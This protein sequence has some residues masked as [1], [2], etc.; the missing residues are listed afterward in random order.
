M[1]LVETVNTSVAAPL[2]KLDI[3][4][5][6][7]PGGRFEGS[8][9]IN[10]TI[11][12]AQPLDRISPNTEPE[13]PIKTA[14]LDFEKDL[15]GIARV[16]RFFKEG[17]VTVPESISNYDLASAKWA[18]EE[19]R[20]AGTVEGFKEYETE[21]VEKALG[22]RYNSAES[23]ITY[24]IDQSF[25]LRNE[26]H[27]D[28]PAAIK[29]ARGNVYLQRQGSPDSEREAKELEGFL[30][31]ESLL[32]DPA[33][34]IDT[35]MMVISPPSKLE[36]SI[37][38]KNFV[39]FYELV[40]DDKTGKRM[41]R[42]T[43]FATDATY[44]EGVTDAYL[45]SHP[46]RID[47]TDASSVEKIFLD[48][49]SKGK[50]VTEEKEKQTILS[51]SKE[52]IKFYIDVLCNPAA[53]AESIA[54]AFQAVLNGADVVG[55]GFERIVETVFKGVTRVF[56]N[57]PTFRNIAE[58]VDWLGRLVVEPVAAACGIS[59]GVSIQSIRK[60]LSGGIGN[61]ISNFSMIFSGGLS[62]I[63]TEKGD[64]HTGDCVSC[65]RA[66]VLVGECDICTSCEQN[67]S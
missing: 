20:L 30:K 14:P 42:M 39:D 65:K 3:L 57:V 15:R 1:S 66:S 40:T 43:R 56:N 38:V 8:F 10:D 60:F 41:V 2:K 61:L 31:V 28:E 5:A 26:K 11:V 63:R 47:S 18:A 21:Q 4:I 22:E 36:G 67:M 17:G 27:S 50:D 6:P 19:A 45:L 44:G 54:L 48:K 7:D 12:F 64:Y 33:T 51:K 23:V 46:T 59:G 53:T 52:R 58:E 24:L 35:K 13:E 62:Y 9:N 37:Y 29:I 32:A 34:P 55:R 49:F 16:R 25:R